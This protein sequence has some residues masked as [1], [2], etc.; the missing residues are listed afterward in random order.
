[1]IICGQATDRNPHYSIKKKR[2]EID[3]LEGCYDVSYEFLHKTEGNNRPYDA[4]NTAYMAK[5]IEDVLF[6]N[7]NW[8]HIRS[9][10]LM[11]READPAAK[12]LDKVIITITEV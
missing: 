6:E 12:Y 2:W 9:V 8:K 10:K 1:M 3:K 7:D 4:T 5:L 11:S